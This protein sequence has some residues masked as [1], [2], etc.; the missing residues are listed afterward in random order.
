MPTTQLG[1]SYLEKRAQKISMSLSVTP[2]RNGLISTFVATPSCLSL[3][4]VSRRFKG[5]GAN[6]SI[7]FH[8]DIEAMDVENKS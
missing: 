1:I 7:S 2:G 4:N 5:G 8:R 6:L 3:C